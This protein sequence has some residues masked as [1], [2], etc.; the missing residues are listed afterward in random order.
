MI[1]NAYLN[2]HNNANVPSEG[3]VN[4][5]ITTPKIEEDVDEE[6]LIS[7]EESK[8][9]RTDRISEKH[10]SSTESVDLIQSHSLKQYN[11]K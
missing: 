2:Q 1:I 5:I 6:D 9:K 10:E 7:R 11:S 8:V 3:L 4:L